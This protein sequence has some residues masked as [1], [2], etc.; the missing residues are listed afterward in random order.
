MEVVELTRR[1]VLLDHVHTF[2]ER[3]VGNVLGAALYAAIMK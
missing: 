1:G 2:K 3:L